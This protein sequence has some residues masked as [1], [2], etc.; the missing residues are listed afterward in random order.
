MSFVIYFRR[1][2][3]KLTCYL[4]LYI[5]SSW[6][7]LHFLFAVVWGDQ[8]SNVSNLLR[9]EVFCSWIHSSKQN[10]MN[11]TD[12]EL[13]ISNYQ[14]FIWSHESLLRIKQQE[15]KY[16]KETQGFCQWKVYIM[17]SLSLFLPYTFIKI[18]FPLLN[19]KM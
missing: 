2:S 7:C 6:P 15:I 14:V 13:I 9:T 5:T 10:T 19:Q 3:K 4:I 11:L 18:H 1:N 8:D 17:S 12:S 16:Q